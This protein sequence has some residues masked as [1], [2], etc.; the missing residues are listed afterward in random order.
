MYV[1]TVKRKRA[2]GTQVAYLQLA[3]NDWDPTAGRSVT[4]VSHSSGPKD[5]PAGTNP[6]SDTAQTPTDADFPRPHWHPGT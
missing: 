2:D 4:S 6:P 1:K 3:H 5:T